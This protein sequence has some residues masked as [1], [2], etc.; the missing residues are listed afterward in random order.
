MNTSSVRKLLHAVQSRGSDTQSVVQSTIVPS[1]ID[2]GATRMKTL[3]IAAPSIAPSSVQSTIVPSEINGG[4]TRMQKKRGLK[5]APPSEISNGC[6]QTN[7]PNR[8]VATNYVNTSGNN[9]RRQMPPGMPAGHEPD[10]E[11]FRKYNL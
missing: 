9:A 10:M 4:A 2:N 8:N 7:R 1:E 11:N 3:R 5:I 6:A